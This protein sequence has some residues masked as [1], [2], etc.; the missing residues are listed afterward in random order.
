[1]TRA[2]TIINDPQRSPEWFA[3]RLGRVTGSKAS[4]VLMG[5]KTAGRADYV[6]QLA[7]ERLTG[8]AEEQGYVSP[9]MLRGVE[10]EPFA[11]MRGESGGAFIRET[12]F[13]RHDKLMIG[14][15]LDG[16]SDDFECVWEFKCPKSTT[17]IKYLKSAGSE[18]LKDYQPQLMHGIYVTSAKQAVIGSFD[19]RMPS[20]LEWVQREVRA[21]DLPIE[22]YE[23]SLMKFLSDVSNM[24]AE[25]RL[26][27][28]GK[29]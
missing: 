4:C 2:F 13:L 26:L 15:S 8:Q 1:M 3:A 16:D 27:Q 10:K 14:T 20:G 21:S 19:D 18:L 9:E 23:K 24:E 28:K 25:L 7:L 22:E 17:H 29:L 12:G 5:E 11:R 6:L